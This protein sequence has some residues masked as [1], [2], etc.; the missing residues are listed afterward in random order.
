MRICLVYDRF[1]PLT[2]GGAERWY[3]NLGERLIAAGHDVT[4]LTLRHWDRDVVPELPGGKVITLGPKLPVHTDDGRR[5]IGPP[6]VFGAFVLAHLLRHGTDYDV[7]HT[8]SFPYFS[9]L[10]A[11]AARRRGRFRIVVDWH[12]VWTRGYWREYLGPAGVLGWLVQ[13]LC[14]RVPHR[15]FCFSRLHLGRLRDEGF[16]G[17]AQVLEGEYAGDAE[18]PGEPVDAESF[19]VYAGRHIPEKRVTA[20]IPAVAEA[21]RRDPELRAEVFGEGPLSEEV[22]RLVRQNGL[23]DAV[24]L[25]GFAPSDE[26]EDALGRAAAMVLPSKREGYGLIV[27]EAASHGT[28]SVVVRDPENA[29]TE[30]IDEGVNGTVA[31]SASAADLADAIERVRAGGVTLRAS[32]AAWFRAN[33]ERLALS[34]SLEQVER[35]Y[36]AE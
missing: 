6:M 25:R 28:P 21:R 10:A 12:E 4:Y 7:V 34:T 14:V 2:L 15:A 26:V 20:L 33:R 19:V 31:A 29:A 23:E 16:R 27:V 11:G 5:R 18:P 1:H 36:A 30:L 22:A 13:K 24:A 17:E 9:V 32:T 8:A 3:R 35:S